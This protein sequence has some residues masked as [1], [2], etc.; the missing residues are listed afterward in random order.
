MEERLAAGAEV[1]SYEAALHSAAAQVRPR[2]AQ[3]PRRVPDGDSTHDESVQRSADQAQGHARLA[4]CALVPRLSAI[5]EDESPVAHTPAPSSATGASRHSRQ[6][7]ADSSSGGSLWELKRC[8]GSSDVPPPKVDVT[9]STPQLR[10]TPDAVVSCAGLSESAGARCES[11][12]ATSTSRHADSENPAAVDVAAVQQMGTADLHKADAS[13]RR[14]P[15]V[16]HRRCSA[17]QI[18]FATLSVELG[19]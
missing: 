19:V 1:S 9:P 10:L 8:R 17:V 6:S 14:A 2:A 11:S 16:R 7:S 3:R 5:L 12:P 18:D 15:F 13:R 4:A